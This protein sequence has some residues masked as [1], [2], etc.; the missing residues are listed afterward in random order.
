[1]LNGTGRNVGLASCPGI[2]HWTRLL[3]E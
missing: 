1:L 2:T 3:S